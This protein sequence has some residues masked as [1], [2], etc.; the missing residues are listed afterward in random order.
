MLLILSMSRDVTL[1]LDDYR[2]VRMIRRLFVCSIR[3]VEIRKFRVDYGDAMSGELLVSSVI[4]ARS[5]VTHYT[6]KP[7]SLSCSTSSA[8]HRSD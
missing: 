2:K 6:L 4:R 5:L 8:M 7:E 3:V 1:K